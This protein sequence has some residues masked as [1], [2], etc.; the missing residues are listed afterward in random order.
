M[1]YNK[2]EKIKNGGMIIYEKNEI[3]F[4]YENIKDRRDEI[5]ESEKILKYNL[6]DYRIKSVHRI[7][8]YINSLCWKADNK[9]MREVHNYIV[10]CLNKLNGNIDGVELTL[11]ENEE[12]DID[13]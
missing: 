6:L 11:N 8:E 5:R 4:L 13:I 3:Q 10:H 7:L 1:V 9:E 12:G 2:S